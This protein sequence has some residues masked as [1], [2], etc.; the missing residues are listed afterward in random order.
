MGTP[1]GIRR[2]KYH[3]FYLTI[4]GREERCYL[5]DLEMSW[6]G[7]SFW[8]HLYAGGNGGVLHPDPKDFK[9]EFKGQPYPSWSYKFKEG[10]L[11]FSVQPAGVSET[12]VAG[13]DL[14]WSWKPKLAYAKRKFELSVRPFFSFRSLHHVGGQE[15]RCEGFGPLAGAT[16]GAKVVGAEGQSALRWNL[17][18]EWT[19]NDAPD[20]YYNFH[21]SDEVARGYPADEN[22]FSAGLCKLSFEGAAT[23]RWRVVS[24][25]TAESI[26]GLKTNSQAL[27]PPKKSPALDFVLVEPAGI[28]AGYPWFGEWGRDTFI[29]L[30]GIV[31][32]WIR[33][34]AD[35][36]SVWSWSREILSR[37]GEW[38]QKRGLLPNLIETG[39]KPQWESSDATLWWT[40]S[41][42]SLWQM[43]L[44]GGAFEPFGRLQAEYGDLLAEAI[45]SIKVGRHAYLEMNAQGLLEVQGA[46]S[47]WMDARVDGQAVT[48]R[49]GVLPEINALWFQAQCLHELWSEQT[50]WDRSELQAISAAILGCQE[51]DRPNTVFLHSIPLSP[52]FVIQDQ[53]R[54]RRDLLWISENFW[55]PVGLRTLAPGN[56]DYRPRCIG[57]QRE[58][59]LGYHQG[60]AWGW[61][62]GHYEMALSRLK[63]EPLGN[64]EIAAKMF[65]ESLLREMPI[66]GHIPEIFDADAPFVPRGAPAQAWSLACL[67]EEQNRRRHRLD[68]KLTRVLARRWSGKEERKR[69]RTQ[70][71][72]TA[73]N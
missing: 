24:E 41:L 66:E 21:F 42:A 52:S 15:W 12:A 43:S 49:T 67:E 45:R 22:L 72:K 37:W 1:Q 65:P 28:V 38:I 46:H 20:W 57:T 6:Q 63:P 26:Q 48:P 16:R 71:E 32:A 61:L 39:G 5:A 69:S 19:W 17:E 4:A 23:A 31:A 60:P 47:T 50:E 13:I 29:S 58:R 36:E 40:H 10:T 3:G 7:Q 68:S 55:T 27:H 73:S 8:P 25:K 54:L 30:P 35:P 2:R 70:N 34:G 62:G 59:D 18:G 11:Q 51:P 33:A 9:V 53:E 44:A 64:A 14:L 56:F